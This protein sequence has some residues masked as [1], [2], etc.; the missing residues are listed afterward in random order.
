MP[1]YGKIH[2]PND[3][4]GMVQSPE[5]QM[6]ALEQ[7]KVELEKQK[8]QMDL[9]VNNAEA[10]LENKKLDLE[11]NKQMLEA[12][13]AGVTTAMKDEKAEADR[14]S[15]ESIK[16]IE[17]MTKLLT[18][19]MN[20]EGLEKRSMTE[21]LKDQANRQDKNEMQA[22]DMILKLIKETTNA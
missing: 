10:A 3:V 13:K 7:A 4:K 9:A 15:K 18:A 1:N 6:V 2:Y 14:A 8:M 20:Q 17:M 12:T 11:E 22:V 5:Q 16:A 19:Q 21:L